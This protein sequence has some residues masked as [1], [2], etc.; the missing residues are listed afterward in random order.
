MKLLTQAATGSHHVH[1]FDLSSNV[2]GPT[3]INWVAAATGVY[4]IDDF[5]V[6]AMGTSEQARLAEVL[7][8]EKSALTVQPDNEAGLSE[9]RKSRMYN[10]NI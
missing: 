10:Q 6:T 5:S 3:A 2:L 4:F 1:S 8:R 7:A 9:R